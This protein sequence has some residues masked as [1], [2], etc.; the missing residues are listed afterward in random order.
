MTPGRTLAKRRLAAELAHRRAL[1][2]APA[3]VQP[4]VVVVA[5]RGL[6]PFAALQR[7]AGAAGEQPRPA[8]D[9]VHAHDPSARVAQVAISGEVTSER[10]HGS[11]SRAVDDVDDR[12]TGPLVGTG[13]RMDAAARP[14]VARRGHGRATATPA[15]G[16]PRRGGR[17]TATSRACQVGVRSSCSAS[18]C[19]SSTT[20]RP[21]PGTAP[22]PPLARRRP[23]RRRHGGLAQSS[24]I[25]ATVRPDSRRR[26]G[27][28]RSLA[29]PPARPRG[30][31][32]IGAVPP[33]LP[34]R[35]VGITSVRGGSRS[36]PPCRRRAWRRSPATS[37]R[38][39]RSSSGRQGACGDRS[40]G[41]RRDQERPEPSAPPTAPRPTRR[42]R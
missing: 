5:D 20:T 11:S 25:V 13:G 32:R 41:G 22:R 18:S 28:Q 2:A 6:A 26:V 31:N 16:G 15:A 12:P 9:V 21:G 8:G 14:D 4:A 27:Q 29:R 10:F 38:A 30:P 39:P 33:R 7:P 40:L 42:D 3:A 24:G 19:S 17:S 35:A 23:R 1:G 36:T 34:T 37:G